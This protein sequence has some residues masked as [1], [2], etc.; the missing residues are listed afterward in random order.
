MHTP[1]FGDLDYKTYR[2]FECYK[3]KEFFLEA[4][5]NCLCSLSLVFIDSSVNFM[6]KK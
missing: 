3:E 5:D 1:M 4:L 2:D 6:C